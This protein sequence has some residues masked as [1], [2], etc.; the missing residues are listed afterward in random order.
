MI[1]HDGPSSENTAQTSA[2]LASPDKTIGL[3]VQDATHTKKKP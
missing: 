3:Y 1:D 2:D